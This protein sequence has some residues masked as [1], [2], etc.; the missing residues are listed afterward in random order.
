[1]NQEKLSHRELEVE[2]LLKTGISNRQIGLALGITEKTIKFH[3]TNIFAKRQ[4]T[5]RTE[6]IVQQKDG[7]PTLSEV[8]AFIKLLE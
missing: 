4:V 3:L 6:L 5:S 7:N 1:M 2:A 8:K